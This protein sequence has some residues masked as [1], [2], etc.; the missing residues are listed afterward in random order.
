MRSLIA[1]FWLT[2]TFVTAALAAPS[3]QGAYLTIHV[4]RVALETD[5]PK[6]AIV[7]SNHALSGG[8]FT[9]LHDGETRMRAPLKPLPDFTEWG[10]NKHYYLADFSALR[11]S[12]RYIVRA[13]DGALKAESGNIIVGNDALFRTITPALL[14]YFRE[15]RWLDARDREI[16]VHGSER[17]VD[18]SGGW[19]DAG[20]DNGKYL[21]HL[22]YANYFNPQ[23]AG[24]TA[25]AMARA[26]DAAPR[27]FAAAGL[28]DDIVDEAFWGADFMH[29]LLSPEG[30]FYMTVFDGWGRPDAEREITGYVG[31]AGK[32]TQDYH[33]AFREGGGMAIAAL[34]RAARLAKQTK[35]SGAFSGAAYLADAERGWAH[36]AANNLK[37][38]D[39]GKENII[40][41]YCALIAAV[42]LYKST[43]KASYRSAADARA[44]NLVN[45]M[46][47]DGWW[48][49]DNGERPYYHGAEAGMPVIAL[50]EY[51][52][53]APPTKAIAARETIKRALD[54]Q[55][56]LDRETEN[57]FDY[58]RQ[59]FRIVVDGKPAA[60]DS[61]FFMPH[62]NETGYWWQGE[63]ARLSSLAAAAV[64][65]GRAIGEKG[66]MFGVSDRLARAAEHRLDWTLGRNPYDISMLY[67]FGQRNPAYADAGGFMLVGGIS[68]GITGAADCEDGS[69]I[70]F[71]PGPEGE[72][73]RWNEQWLPHSTWMLLAVAFLNPDPPPTRRRR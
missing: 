51:L 25:W 15:S 72:N 68:N 29:R 7:E 49:S 56:S 13:N 20:G 71:S 62:A 24:F 3:P 28:A 64:L 60:I 47:A 16:R 12:G 65:G 59:Q 52:T 26:Y 4:N 54:A 36:L 46:T 50:A 69:G 18:A 9:V 31:A 58:P 45:R 32:Y 22:S 48:R 34:A 35:R 63:S 61:G 5:G 44:G 17:I 19:K 66:K 53:I 11:H 38:V 14:S 57:P 70:A 1:A 73:W 21:S 23:Q 6:S 8:E 2:M 33:A 39:D 42:E 41:D 67:G 40:D 27:R 55:D 10:E 30:Y 37:Y 43:G